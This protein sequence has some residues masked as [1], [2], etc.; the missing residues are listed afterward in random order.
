MVQHRPNPEGERIFYSDYEE[1]APL[2]A[3]EIGRVIDIF[4]EVR[5][6]LM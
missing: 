2:T 3:D 5:C 4:R 1:N 6:R